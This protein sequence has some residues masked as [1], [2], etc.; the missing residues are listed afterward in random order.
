[1]NLDPNG[2]D[3]VSA[4]VR[5]SGVFGNGVSNPD[6]KEPKV[7][8]L[9]IS[10]ERELATDLAVRV[11]ALYSRNTDNYRALNTKRAYSDFNIPIANLDPGP[12]GRL[13]T[14]DDTGK[15]IT[16][17]DYP[18][19]LAGRLF[20]VPALFNPPDSDSS[21]KTI[22]F[23]GSKRLSEGWQFQASYSATKINVPYPDLAD[24]NPNAEIN[25]ANNTWEWGA[26]ASGTYV[27]PM[28]I[29]TSAFVNHVS[30][31]PQARTVLFTGG[32]QIPSLLVNVEPIGT[33]RLPSTTTMDLRVEKSL[34]FGAARKLTVRASIYNMLNANTVTA[35]TVQSGANYLRATAF[36]PPRFVE[37]G[38]SFNY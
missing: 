23:A 22:E 9:D 4:A 20:Q 2:P 35:R 27:F 26:K 37:F 30:G 29:A 16:Y 34:S 19:S 31:A 15:T 14:G 1:M 17:F 3:F 32:R 13:G 21:F 38:A 11:S 7:D 36:I 28:D 8:Q 5:D 25:T 10:L 6:E 24:F 33:L 12:D 18:A